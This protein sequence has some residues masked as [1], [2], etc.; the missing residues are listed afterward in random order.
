M[1]QALEWAKRSIQESPDPGLDENWWGGDYGIHW[2]YL[3]TWL[4]E[5]KIS[6]EILVRWCED[7]LRIPRLHLPYRIHTQ[8]LL[9]D[10]YEFMNDSAKADAILASL[11]APRERDWMVI[12]P[13]DAPADNPFPEAAPFGLL[14]DLA[15]TH[16]GILNKEI[17]WEPWED[18]EPMDG[19][20]RISRSALKKVHGEGFN[21]LGWGTEAIRIPSV[22]YS[23]IYVAAPTAM[24]VQVRTGA[25]MLRIWLNEN[26]TPV[27]KEDSIWEAIPDIE[28][29]DVLLKAGLNRFLVATAFGSVNSFDLTFRITDLDGNAIP[30]LKYVSAMEVSGSR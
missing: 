6:P 20:L 19:R 10:T 18:A 9:A 5:G 17:Q 4:R 12:G 28:V 29:N 22:A 27:I 16:T 11:G 23:C 26:S 30:G 3:A 15:A 8:Y 24:E 14:T 25:S 1:E 21:N 7:V 2:Y 13:F